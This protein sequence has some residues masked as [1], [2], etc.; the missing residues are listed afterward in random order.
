[1]T[2]STNFSEGEVL[3][4]EEIA[5]LKYSAILGLNIDTKVIH[6]ELR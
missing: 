5:L 4:R 6:Q 1:M 3:V 2:S